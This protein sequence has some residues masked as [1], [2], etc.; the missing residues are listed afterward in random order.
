MGTDHHEFIVSYKDAIKLIDTALDVYDEPF[1]DSSAIPT[2]LVSKLAKQY[3]TVTLSGEG[4]DELFLGYG[5]YKWANRL[6]NPLLHTFRKPISS[7][8][9][10]LPTRYQRVGKLLDYS[11]R[12]F[13]KSH[14]FSQEQYL[15]SRN[16]L[17]VMLNDEYKS[18]KLIGSKDSS[19]FLRSYS[20]PDP[21]ELANVEVR[22]LTSM[23]SQALFDLEYYLQDDLLT[24]VD[25]AS[26]HYSLETRVPYL[27][28]RLVEM[29]LNVSPNL[30]YKNGMPKYILKE[31]LYQYLPKKFFDRP[32]QGF[33]IPLNKWLHHEL[34]YLLD[35]YLSESVINQYQVV[36]YTYVKNLLDRFENGSDYLFNRIWL[37]VVLHRWLKINS[38]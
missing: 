28:H 24:K 12:D 3:V 38:N 7:L 35:E 30:K 5:A 16:E 26:M 37:L 21:S 11:H 2:M 14:I 34:H 1:A 25:R 15:F 27:D 19:N 13:I 17:S 29:A 36:S 6:N 23:E 18:S 4:G 31:I 22:K 32:K 8:F 9:A 33:A 10:H 20:T